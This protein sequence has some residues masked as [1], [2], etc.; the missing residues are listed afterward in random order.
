M[1]R[2]L[3]LALS[4]L[5]TGCF[6]SD[7]EEL[8]IPTSNSKGALHQ[9]FNE[10]IE[11]E[12][13]P[14]QN[15]LLSAYRYNHPDSS[16]TVLEAIQIQEQAEQEIALKRQA[17]Q[18]SEYQQYLVN[19]KDRIEDYRKEASALFLKST[20][21]TVADMNALLA[22]DINVSNIR[23]SDYKINK[24]PSLSSDNPKVYRIQAQYSFDVTNRNRFAIGFIDGEFSLD[25]ALEDVQETRKTN[26]G[27][28]S[29]DNA[30]IHGKVSFSIQSAA[31]ISED[32]LSKIV[33]LFRLN[34]FKDKRNHTFKLVDF[35]NYK[36]KLRF[37]LDKLKELKATL[38]KDGKNLSYVKSAWKKYDTFSPKMEREQ[39]K[40]FEQ[41]LID[42][43]GL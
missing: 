30:P 28:Y 34:T 16:I 32:E 24:I 37:R 17:E 27:V 43:S 1:K 8:T 6:S 26:Q 25:Y 5:L 23:L 2:L 3:I 35:K 20:D 33:P 39:K 15:Q 22:S 21:L 18:N 41:Y 9:E 42:N 40:A 13:T 36:E 31:K 19:S 10:R 12:L 7:V 38:E 29:R 4:I 11:K 14:N